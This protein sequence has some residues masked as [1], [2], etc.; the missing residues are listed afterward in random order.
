MS[1]AEQYIDAV[2]Q[3]DIERLMSLFAPTATLSHPAGLFAD[4][5]AIRNFYESIVFAGKAVTEIVATFSDGDAEILQIRAS[6]PLGEPGN[7]VH[8]ADV[9]RIQDG[10]IA[11]LDIYYR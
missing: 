2:N 4:A 9:F 11:Q 7:Y 10:L 1:I 3:A 8:A 6:S 5:D